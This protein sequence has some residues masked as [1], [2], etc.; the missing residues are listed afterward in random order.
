MAACTYPAHVLVNVFVLLTIGV[1][2]FANVGVALFS[3]V[4]IEVSSTTAVTLDA[5]HGSRLRR[6]TPNFPKVMILS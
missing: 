6:G 2:V 4:E 3:D 5:C 1:Y